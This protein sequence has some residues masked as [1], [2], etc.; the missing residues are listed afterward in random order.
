MKIRKAFKADKENISSLH[1]ASIRKLYY[2]HYN[3]EQLNAW[4]SVLK[5][6]VYDHALKE[7][8]FLVAY[9]P[10][11]DLL[12][13]GILPGSCRKNIAFIQRNLKRNIRPLAR[14]R[15]GSKIRMSYGSSKAEF[16]GRKKRP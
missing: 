8:V 9:N 15:I 11:Q 5:P 12:G 16:I 6:S 4:T 13:L 2:N 10:Q 14:R 3:R 1:I 7:K